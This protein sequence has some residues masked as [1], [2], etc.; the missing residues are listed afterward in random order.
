MI[1][2]IILLVRYDKNIL[3]NNIDKKIIKFKTLL[4]KYINITLVEAKGRMSQGM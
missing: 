4:D 2:N 1:F 3:D